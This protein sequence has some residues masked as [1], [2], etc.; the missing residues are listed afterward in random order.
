MDVPH[1]R[2]KSEALTVDC[3]LEIT[4]VPRSKTLRD[5]WLETC[6]QVLDVLV[7]R[8]SFGPGSVSA[9][10]AYFGLGIVAASYLSAATGTLMGNIPE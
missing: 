5:Q 4:E 3:T 8:R 10:P 6:V 1:D 7:K 2:G 9:L